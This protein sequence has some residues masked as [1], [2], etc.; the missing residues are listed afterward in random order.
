MEPLQGGD[1]GVFYFDEDTGLWVAAS[2]DD[3]GCFV[4]KGDLKALLGVTLGAGDPADFPTAAPVT[5][6]DDDDDVAPAP[7]DDDDDDDS[8][9]T[10]SSSG[11]NVGMGGAILF[12]L[13][14]LGLLWFKR[15]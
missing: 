12:L 10:S 5:D 2:E 7:T 8:G 11:C 4:F 9:L 15:F 6:D 13:A 1:F 3:E 14:P